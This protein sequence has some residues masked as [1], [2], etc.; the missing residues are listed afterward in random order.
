MAEDHEPPPGGQ[1]R[2]TRDVPR[3][4]GSALG[5]TVLGAVLPGAG[6]VA[7]GRRV[8]GIVVLTVLAVGVIFGLAILLVEPNP[9]MLAAELA[10]RPTTLN[11]LGAVVLAAGLAWVTVIVSSHLMLRPRTASGWQRGLGITVVLVLCAAVLVPS[12]RVSQYA[13]ATHDFV[14]NVFPSTPDGEDDGE[15]PEVD[16]EDPWKGQ[17]RVNLMLLGGDAGEDRDG[18]RTDTTMVASINTKTGDTVLFS[19]PRNLENMPFPRSS[20]MYDYWPDGFDCGYSGGCILNSIYGFGRTHADDYP[21]TV[22]DPGAAAL[23]DAV[24]AALG[25]DIDY[26]LMVDL[27][28]FERLV[29]ALGGIDIDVGP[30]R[31]PIGGTDFYGNDQPEWKIEEWIEAGE[32]HLDGREALWFSRSR[33]RSDD[34]ERME[35]Q[36]CV[37]N[38]VVA[39]ANPTNVL[40]NYLDL[41]ATAEDIVTTDVPYQLFP[42]FVELADR[43]QQQPIRSLPFTN[44]VIPDS[45]DP[46][47]V[48]IRDLVDEALDPPPVAPPVTEPPTSEPTDD[49]TDP[50]ES[51]SPTPTVDPTVAVAADEVCG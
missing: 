18:L 16:R 22:A 41:A 11:V 38:A 46:D 21:A 24:G 47:F 9:R 20:P 33:W 43:V 37:V 29:D 32:Q 42:A 25:L 36:R 48:D 26:F 17:G 34:Y 27:M 15:Q 1:Q 4:F 14:R 28:G 2:R 6:F 31:V 30:E 23:G 3:S 13:F 12:A 40:T 5:L 51:A 7:A 19:L 45:S 10:S 50:T 8:L 39:Q 44:D 49:P 35:R